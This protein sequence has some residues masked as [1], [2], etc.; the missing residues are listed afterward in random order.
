MFQLMLHAHPRIAVPPETRFLLE[1]YR[2]HPDFGDLREE[3]NR[4]RVARAVVRPRRTRFADLGVPRRAVVR[5]IV[6]AP[7]TLGSCLQVPFQAYADKF[8]KPRWGVK[9]PSYFRYVD[10]LLRLYPNAQFVHLV[11]D[12]RDAAASLLG[13]TWFRGDIRHATAIWAD[14][15]DYADRNA[16]RL[17]ADQ[18][19]ELRYEDLVADAE[20]QLRRLCAFLGEDYDPRMAQ[21]HELASVAVPE[22]KVWHAR[23]HETPNASTVGAYARRMSAEDRQLIDSVLAGRLRARGYVPATDVSRPSPAALA[24]YAKVVAVR[25]ATTARAHLGDRLRDRRSPTPLAAVTPGFDGS[26]TVP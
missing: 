17:A 13:M 4:R 26:V 1:V 12:G 19:F 10:A 23:T 9:R 11:R 15:M 21:P 16:R 2:R 24:A 8:D 5:G 3:G 22:R 25:R 20:P 6:E 14:A 7:P 18:W